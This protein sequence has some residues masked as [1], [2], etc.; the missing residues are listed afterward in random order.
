MD[1]E[2]MDVTSTEATVDTSS[3]VEQTAPDTSAEEQLNTEGEKPEKGRIP[4]E[5]FQEKVVELNEMKEQ[6]A[7]LRAKAEIADRLSQVVSPVDDPRQKQL[8]AARRELES[9]GYVDKD[10]VAQLIEAKLNEYKWQ[11]RFVSQMDQLEKKYDGKDGSPK[12][13]PEKVADFMDTQYKKGN[14]ITDPETAFKMMNLDRLAESKAKSQKSSTYS[15]APGRPVHEETDQ[16]KADLAAAA[17]TGNVSEFLKK[18]VS[19]P[20]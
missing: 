6:M 15:E 2:E 18:Y 7:E 10:T 12:F 16:R 11:E 19:I 20:D 17:Q 8:E 14:V 4:Y 5:R 1:N 3:D 9:M 13:D